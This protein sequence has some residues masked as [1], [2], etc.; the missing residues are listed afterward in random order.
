MTET[1][2]PAATPVETALA[3]GGPAPEEKLAASVQVEDV[4]PCRRRVTVE[5]TKEAVEKRLRKTF[6]EF[7]KE[8]VLPGFRRGHA[9]RPLI[10]KRVGKD[11]RE[12]LK[13]KLIMEVLEQSEELKDLRA[14]GEP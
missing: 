8:N 13:G 12:Q 10:E 5:V 11:L 3:T 4:G 6:D 9:P 14:I 2:D 7:R 1:K